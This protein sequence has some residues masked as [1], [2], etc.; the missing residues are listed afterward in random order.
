MSNRIVNGFFK[1]FLFVAFFAAGYFYGYE[2]AQQRILYLEK[3]IASQTIEIEKFKQHIQNSKE[4][5]KMIKELS[6]RITTLEEFIYK[7]HK[8]SPIIKKEIEIK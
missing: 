6:R 7:N 2:S 4:L 3:E 1:F 8:D 5:E